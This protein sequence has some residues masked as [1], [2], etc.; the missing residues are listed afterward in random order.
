[1]KTVNLKTASPSVGELLAMAR[2][3]S[4]LLV[5]KNGET[6]VLEEADEFD[7]EVAE[8]GSSE[9]FMKFLSKRSKESASTSIEQFVKRLIP[10]THNTTLQPPS[11]AL[12]KSKSQKNPRAAR[13]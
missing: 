13:G 12:R 1:M 8:L 3:K 10:A 4:L 6:F 5:S 11:R 2:K 9:K 7:Q